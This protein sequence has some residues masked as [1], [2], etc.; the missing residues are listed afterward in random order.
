MKFNHLLW[1]GLVAV[2]G[3]VA[4]K[5][6]KPAAPAAG[7]GGAA[8]AIPTYEAVLAVKK[9]I[10]RKVEA[11]GTIMPAEN[12]DI[13]PEISGR[14]V[15]IHFQ[16]GSFV[17]RGALLVKLFDQDLQA[18]LKKLAVQLQVAEATEKR[19]SELLA[20]NGTSQQDYDIARLNV[21]N[22]KADMEM[23]R[24]NISRTQI[25]APYA[26]RIGLRNISLGA[27]VT[28]ATPITNIAQVSQT[29]VEFTVPEMYAGA[30]QSGQIVTLKP[31]GIDRTYSARIIAT[32]N[33]IAEDTRNLL[34][35][36]LVQ[37]S[38]GY[39]KPGSFVQ[40]SIHIGGE[41]EAILVPTQAI[42]PST[43]YKTVFISENGKAVSR[44]IETGV[45]DSANIE[46]TRGLSAG[47]TVITTGLL[48]VKEGM[49]IKVNLKNN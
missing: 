35:R 32:E 27:Y 4:C 44:Q 40:A 49:D 16:E 10:E 19:Q 33:A 42:I 13:H 17:Q 47:D 3:A 25:R 38:D 20:I 22:I 36:A 18:E 24:V 23:L 15:G 26:G 6:E 2:S 37:K 39:L 8:R 7:P 46:I 31:S 11:P 29:K 21:S 5:D 14:V 43:R 48:S 30:M 12:T 45:R 9:P 28:P 34:V 41:Q 1:I